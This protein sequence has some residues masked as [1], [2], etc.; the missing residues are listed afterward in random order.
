ARNSPT[1]LHDPGGTSPPDPDPKAKA[2]PKEQAAAPAA[3]DDDPKN[4]PPDETQGQAQNVGFS[5]GALV[6][7]YDRYLRG[8]IYTTEITGQGLHTFLTRPAS[9]AGSLLFHVR[10]VV[11]PG[12]EAGLQGGFGGA[13]TSDQPV[14]GTGALIGTLHLGPEYDQF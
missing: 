2:P 6:Q 9:G 13:G 5:N 8:G 14:T 7:P 12:V 3:D 10:D 11:A 4:D 1:V